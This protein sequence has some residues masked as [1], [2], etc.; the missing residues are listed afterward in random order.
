MITELSLPPQQLRGGKMQ[1]RSF[2]RETLP[3]LAMITVECT[4]VGL[5]VLSKAALNQGMNNF[6]SV[7]YC[8][9]SGTLILLPYF[10]FHRNRR[11]PLTFSLLWRFFLVALIMSSGQIIAYTGIKFSS[12][13]LLSA[14]ANLSPVFTFLLAVIFRF[15]KLELRRSSGL[16]K[17]LGAVIAVTGAFIITLY[18]GPE[19]LMASSTYSSPTPHRL[20]DSQQSKWVIGGFL[21]LLTALSS[22]TW[23]ISQASTVKKYPEEMTIVFF[24]TLFVAIQ[25][26][27]FSAIAERNINA[28]K[29]STMVEV[30]AIICTAIFGSVF[31]IAVHTWCLRKKGPIYVAMFKPLGMAAAVVLTVIFL[32]STL[33]LGSVIGSIVI[34]LGFYSVIWGQMKERNMAIDIE[35]CSLG[36]TSKK[37]PLLQNSQDISSI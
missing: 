7:V 24:C 29:L 37:T 15:E 9:A 34:A 4:D 8:N 16:A 6:V 22:A 35:N 30:L 19:L 2:S 10:L 23:N 32:G 20:L 11:P 33:F 25:A 36:S 27:V 17:F 3:F 18:Q 14:M 21:L 5:S 12:P 13:T 26:A 31:R 28:W 1:L